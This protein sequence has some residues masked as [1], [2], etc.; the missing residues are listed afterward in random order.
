LRAGFG[1]RHTFG[2]TG[3]AELKSL[4]PLVYGSAQKH[5]GTHRPLFGYE[6]ERLS[7]THQDNQLYT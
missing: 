1:D 5:I 4:L 7:I 6:R 3:K 2:T